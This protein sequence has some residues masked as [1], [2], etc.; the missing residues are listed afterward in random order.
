MPSLTKSQRAQLRQ[1][2][3]TAHSRELTAAL[4]DLYEEFGHWGGRENDAFDLNEAVHKF[5]DGISRDLYK[6]YVLG[7][8]GLSVTYALQNGILGP[9]EV[10]EELKAALGMPA[11]R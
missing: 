2:A 6:R 11:R 1:L 4:T 3:A 10:D 9:D 7:S 5:H 8:V